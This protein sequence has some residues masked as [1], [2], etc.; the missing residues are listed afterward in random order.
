[1]NGFNKQDLLAKYFA[2]NTNEEENKILNDWLNENPINIE[3]YNEYKNVWTN[4]LPN[5]ETFKTKNIWTNISTAT[6][7]KK[8][9][10]PKTKPAYIKNNLL[11]SAALSVIIL[12]VFTL[13]YFNVFS[14]NQQTVEQIHHEYFTKIGEVNKITLD[15][16]STVTLNSNSSLIIKDDFNQKKRVVELK[17]EAFFEVEHNK[18]L[19]F[20]VEFQN[21]KVKVLGTKF[22]INSLIDNESTIA[23]KEGKVAVSNIKDET[24]I[25]YLEKNEISRVINNKLLSKTKSDVENNYLYWLRDEFNLY[26]VSFKEVIVRLE[27]K[28]QIDIKIKNHSLLNRHITANFNKHSL[29]DIIEILSTILNQKITKEKNIITFYDNR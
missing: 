13:Y 18:E 26:N 8:K 10:N 4:T 23:V 29:E 3:I 1:M 21:G 2:N 20:I 11:L 17:G 16:G 5:K 19:P 9:E 14:I 22:N 25:I 12:T 15:D 7:I 6:N 28:Y 27:N 24:E